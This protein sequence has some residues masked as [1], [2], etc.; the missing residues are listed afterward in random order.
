MLTTLRTQ[1]PSKTEKLK[2]I[3][4]PHLFFI[5][6]RTGYYPAT[7]LRKQKFIRFLGQK[8]HNPRKNIKVILNLGRTGARSSI[9]LRRLVFES[10]DMLYDVLFFLILFTP[11]ISELLAAGVPMAR[12]HRTDLLLLLLSLSFTT[13]KA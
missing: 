1:Q 8:Q 2:S 10:A 9:W 12:V 3:V 13:K 5:S 6:S 4:R 11:S 7:R